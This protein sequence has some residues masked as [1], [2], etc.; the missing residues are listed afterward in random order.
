MYYIQKMQR[1]IIM[2][3]FTTFPEYVIV[4]FRI[5]LHIL[6]IQTLSH[7]A[8]TFLPTLHPYSSQ[9]AAKLISQTASYTWA[10][11]LVTCSF[12]SFSNPAQVSSL[13]E[14]C[15]APPSAVNIFPP[16]NTSSPFSQGTNSPLQSCTTV[17][18]TQ[19]MFSV[20]KWTTCTENHTHPCMSPP[21]LSVRASYMF[22]N[23]LV[24]RFKSLWFWSFL[25]NFK[26]S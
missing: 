7:L 22:L 19:F 14:L 21:T 13:Q 9:P 15:F 4:V 5:K 25:T 17:V 1:Y 18:R 6:A 20:R 11:P 23:K 26:L 3:M 16:H 24:V 2:F 10:F 8:P 12:P